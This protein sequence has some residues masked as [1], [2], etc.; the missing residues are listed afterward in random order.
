MQ[1]IVVDDGSQRPGDDRACSTALPPRA[2]SSSCVRR[3]AAS[4]PRCA[5]V[6]RPP[7]P[8]TS[9]SSLQTTSSTPARS[10]TLPTRSTAAPQHDFA[11]GHSHHFG[12][13]DFVR[14]A[15]P[16][17]PWILLYSNL[18]EAACLYRRDAVN[19]VGGFPDG[20]GYEDW[21]LFMALAERDSDGTAGRPSRV[22]LPRS[23]R[24]RAG[25]SGREDALPRALRH[26]AAQSP[27]T[28]RA[29]AR[30][31]SGVTRCRSGRGS[32]TGS[33]SRSRYMCRRG[34]FVRCSRSRAACVP[35]SPGSTP[36]GAD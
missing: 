24:S 4:P 8:S 15:A 29:R 2:G 27:G 30:A 19:A 33:S 11:Y 31:A 18:W 32:S 21:E 5:P 22:P 28:V 3:T 7:G 10:A 16:W 35:W 6:S 26:A 13:V 36:R 9:S 23:R 25:Q 20:T 34:W 14:R 12:A 17:N 1:I